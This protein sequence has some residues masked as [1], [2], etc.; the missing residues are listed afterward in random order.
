[1]KSILRLSIIILI[2]ALG[3]VLP[4]AD[5]AQIGAEMERLETLSRAL[6]D[7]GVAGVLATALPSP[8]IRSQYY[9]DKIAAREPERRALEQAKRDFGLKL[10]RALDDLA[11]QLQKHT[12][13]ADRASQASLLLDLA[14]WL[15][16]APGYGNYILFSRS[17]SLATVPLAYLT[18]DL[19]YSLAS[20]AALRRRI[21]SLPEERAFRV[22]VLNAEA[23]RPFI[24]ALGG[25]ESDQ[26]NQMQFAWGKGWKAMSDWFTTKTIPISQWK[27]DAL[28]EELAFFLDDHAPQPF[29]SVNLWQCK[30]HNTL[31]FGHR[32]KQVENIDRFMLFREEVG[33]FPTQPPRWWKPDDKLYTATKAAFEHAWLPFE[34]QYGPIFDVAEM[35]Y[36][37][38]TD[39]QFLDRDTQYTRLV[40]AQKRTQNGKP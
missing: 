3:S 26:D 36:Q 18:A 24:G 29:T 12:H 39:G 8:L 22:I 2:A 13:S 34:K 5:S 19:D 31:I 38:V 23:S 28:S 35:V 9:A 6:E 21:T 16:A 17:E 7:R 25:G 11:A 4:A 20:V 10:A 37:Q 32:D 40:E 30:L 14:A 33:S 1:M 27:R 15:K